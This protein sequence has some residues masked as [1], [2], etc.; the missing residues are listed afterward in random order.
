MYSSNIVE[1][2]SSHNNS[3][4]VIGDNDDK[5]LHNNKGKYSKD[6]VST[7]C[8]NN[9][10]LAKNDIYEDVYNASYYNN[11]NIKDLIVVRSYN[12]DIYI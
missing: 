6:K 7:L 12:D 2:N 11:Y 3:V 1:Y 9:D 8:G 4:C 10:S 5:C